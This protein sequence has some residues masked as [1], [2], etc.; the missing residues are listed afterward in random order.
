MPSYHKAV[1]T[2]LSA[3]DYELLRQ[4]MRK[5]DLSASKLLAGLL[6]SGTVT[7]ELPPQP[8]PLTNQE[9]IRLLSK[10][11]SNLNQ[12]ARRMNAA[13]MDPQA[14]I[15]AHEFSILNKAMTLFAA[16]FRGLINTAEVCEGLGIVQWMERDRAISAA[17]AKAEGVDTTQEGHPAAMSSG[18]EGSHR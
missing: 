14:A 1:T 10:M 18:P 3:D 17:A 2:Y 16:H 4:H 5:T 7:V 11:S 15:T 13:R 9:A 12:I 6:R 8:E